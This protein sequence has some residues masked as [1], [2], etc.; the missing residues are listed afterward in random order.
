MKLILGQGN[1]GA[2]YDRTRHNVGFYT[3]DQLA[4]RHGLTWSLKTKFRALTAE[5]TTG[6][7]KIVLVKPTT[8]YNETGLSAR[9]LV[10]FYSLDPARDLLV[11][12]DD[13][14]L[15]FGTIRTRKQGSDAGNN[16][17]KSL[18][19]HLG[20]GYHRI[21]IG[22]SNELR[23]HMEDTEFVLGRFS[24][25]EIRSLRTSLLPKAVEFIDDF[26]GDGLE[27]TSHTT[28]IISK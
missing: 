19:S 5:I 16:G 17:I 4:Q 28:D 24:Q 27:A 2:K 23:N 25:T 6:E 1:P 18:N 26:C 13:L 12:H 9:Q 3:L 15:P 11:V 10:D 21:R 14:A 7:E 22:I 20:T 8:F